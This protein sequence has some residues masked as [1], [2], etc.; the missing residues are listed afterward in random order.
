MTVW[1]PPMI[2]FIPADE[3]K[4][5]Q[6]INTTSID[7]LNYYQQ[8]LTTHIPLKTS[9]FN[10]YPSL[11]LSS[12]VLPFYST[13]YSTF[14]SMPSSAY[15]TLAT[16]IYS[17][18]L[19]KSPLGSSLL[20]FAG[21]LLP[22]LPKSDLFFCLSSFL[23]S[24]PSSLVF[25][26]SLQMVTFLHNISYTVIK[27]GKYI[28][29]VTAPLGPPIRGDDCI[30]LCLGDTSIISIFSIITSLNIYLNSSSIMFFYPFYL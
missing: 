14:L 23:H 27:V 9:F 4:L 15:S 16:S 11:S 22:N 24:S 21:L 25:S 8:L 19:S 17:S 12:F 26:W 1:T 30:E 18:S 29:M 5:L 7:S 20:R 10:L 13:F 2:N 28:Y 6:P 3:N